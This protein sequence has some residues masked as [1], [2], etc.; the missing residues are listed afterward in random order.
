MPSPNNIME[1]LPKVASMLSHKFGINVSFGGVTAFT[2]G[3]TI[4]IPTLPL[5]NSEYLVLLVSGYLDHEAS[6]IRFTDFGL[7]HTSSM[8]PIVKH[9]WNIIEDWRVEKEMSCIYGGCK[10]N[11][12]WLVENILFKNSDEQSPAHNPQ[13]EHIVL[14]FL[15]SVVRAWE[16]PCAAPHRAQYRQLMQQHFPRILPPIEAILEECRL[17]CASTAEAIA[18]AHAIVTILQD[19]VSQQDK[20]YKEGKK[21]EEAE[22]GQEAEK[23]YLSQ[24]YQEDEEAP[25]KQQITS[26]DILKKL[27]EATSSDLP[28]DMGEIIKKI[29]NT[30]NIAAM[31]SHTFKMA[32]AIPASGEPL[33]ADIIQAAEQTTNALR[34]KLQSLLQSFTQ[35]RRTLGQRGKIA[36]THLHKIYTNNTKIF[37]RRLPKKEI[38]TAIHLLMDHSGS[39]SYDEKYNSAI[40]ATFGLA[41]ALHTIHGINIGIS[42]FPVKERFCPLIQQ[43]Y[44]YDVARILKHGE[45]LHQ[46]MRHIADGAST[47]LGESILWCIGELQAQKQ[48][49]KILILITDGI[50]DSPEL[51]EQ[52]ILLAQKQGIEVYGLSILSYGLSDYPIPSEVVTTAQ[53]IA[54]AM[55]K[56]L[57]TA[58]TK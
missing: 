21:D 9:V 46:N 52:A 37:E 42:K 29:L 3:K 4:N 8:K 12:S 53:D 45:R 10:N 44:G 34:V 50:A 24:E 32:K 36:T 23:D 41:K 26:K 20:E 55:F 35:N 16:Y 19:E 47:P 54:P 28:Q 18:Y 15:L 58:L 56:I 6:H 1:A 5:E 49:R 33:G 57:E 25:Q 39:M 22:E 38:D 51:T 7:L 31:A 14:S 17:Q 11:F 30:L 43:Y 2:D 48:S 27:L 40:I 13:L